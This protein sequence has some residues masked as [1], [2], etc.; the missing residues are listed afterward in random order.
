M[1]G[2]GVDEAALG[3]WR[4]QVE[5]HA[6]FRRGFPSFF[7]ASAGAGIERC[8]DEYQRFR[9]A[10][11]LWGLH[12]WERD[13]RW[14]HHALHGAHPR[15]ER[16]RRTFDHQARSQ[17]ELLSLIGDE[18]ACTRAADDLLGFRP[19]PETAWCAPPV[20]GVQA[21]RLRALLDR[22]LSSKKAGRG[23]EPPRGS[24]PP[25]PYC[26]AADSPL[27]LP[28][29]AATFARAVEAIEREMAEE[30]TAVG[31]P[32]ARCPGLDGM[33]QRREE[34]MRGGRRV[35]GPTRPKSS[36]HKVFNSS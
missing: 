9:D 21:R 10:A 6:Q 28:C 31:C 35:V 1:G 25:G 29:N 15:K 18:V 26:Y 8:E 16:N 24:C 30:R 7:F 11:V 19:A 27:E 36:F 17:D 2:L 20:V 4:R 23:Q 12:P 32:R 13:A 3:R 22:C 14:A 34:G 5:R 33:E